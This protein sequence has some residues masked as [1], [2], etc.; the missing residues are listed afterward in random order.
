MAGTAARDADPLVSVVVTVVDGGA[1]L[2]RFL[3]A[4]TT[5]EDAPPLEVIVPYDASIARTGDLA[6]RFPS[7]TFLDLG[8]LVPGKPIAS[9]AGQHE[10]YDRRRSQG[11]ARARGE[12][13]AILEDRGVPRKD[14]ARSVVR[15][16]RQPSGV[17]GGAIEPAN[18]GLLNWAF[19][20]TDFGRYGLPFPSGPA[21]WVSD[22]NVTYKRGILDS[23]RE[24]W[25]DRF[26]EPVVHW[27]LLERGETLYLSSEIVVEHNRPPATLGVLI[28]ERFHW[29]R[30]FGEIRAR[31]MSLAKRAAYAVLS[32][33]IP[34]VLL[35]RHGWTQLRKGRF[36]R[37]LRAAPAVALLTTCWTLGE[38]VGT[39]TKR[40]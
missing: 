11:L 19:W 5:Q 20:V 35:V 2:E 12:I 8:A 25:K 33:L 40:A 14:W 21:T 22:V 10:L 13:V 37:Y 27:A 36:L 38:V 3:E 15:L 30:L 6:K 34:L 7:V 32:P 31:H 9:A 17:I 18:V 23:T 29:G 24:L 4:M 39:V 16:H 28:P 1:V 26:Q